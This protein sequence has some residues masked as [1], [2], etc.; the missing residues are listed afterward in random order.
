MMV[1]AKKSVQGMY[2]RAL[3]GAR[4]GYFGRDAEP[5]VVLEA[6][7]GPFPRARVGAVEPGS[8]HV[9]ERVGIATVAD[10]EEESGEVVEDANETVE[11]TRDAAC[12]EHIADEEFVHGRA[13]DFERVDAAELN[14]RAGEVEFFLV[15]QAREQCDTTQIVQGRC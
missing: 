2:E 11:I 5:R 3:R 14:S 1:Y 10:G 15:A 6:L 7:E 13:H 8:D 12:G 4:T 9:I